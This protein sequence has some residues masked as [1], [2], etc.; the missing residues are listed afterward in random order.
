MSEHL[1]IT[2]RKPEDECAPAE[3]H[4]RPDPLEHVRELHDMIACRDLRLLKAGAA[5]PVRFR[6]LD[7][8]GIRVSA[9]HSPR[10]RGVGQRNYR[11]CRS[12]RF[13]RQ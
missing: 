10:H 3:A 13:L 5:S 1:T 11:S 9:S 12:A 7:Q 6:R 4:S 8:C 2:V